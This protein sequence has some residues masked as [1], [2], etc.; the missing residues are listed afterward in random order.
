MPELPDLEVFSDNLTSELKDA[1]LKKIFVCKA[2]NVNVSAAKLKRFLAG[3][4]LDHVY[5]DGK[6]LRFLFDNG[7]ILGFHMMLHGEL[8]FAESKEKLN[9]GIVDMHFENK[10]L[11]L[12]DFQGRARVT[13]NPEPKQAPDVF[14]NDVNVNFWK[15]NLATKATIKNV[16][17]DQKV[18]RG[19][20]NA[21]ADEILWKAKIS[22][23]S[24]GKKIP[25]QKITSLAKAIRSVLTN[26]Q[27]K[28]KKKDPHIIGGEIRDFLVIHNSHKTKSPGGARILTKNNAGRKTYYTKEQ[29]LY[30]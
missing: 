11:A 1:T 2:S 13:L 27:K 12:T 8:K 15:K 22:P 25:F 9:Y 16:L 14:D 4:K 20:G 29:V 18:V 23:F 17:M 26:A 30:K 10:R 21:Y 6:E 7:N 19:I 3:H 24:I 5:R 28:I